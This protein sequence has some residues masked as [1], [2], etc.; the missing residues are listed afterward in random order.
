MPLLGL[1]VPVAYSVELAVT[2]VGPVEVAAVVQTLPVL[3]SD[4][5]TAVIVAGLAEAVVG[6]VA[7]V[8]DSRYFA[9]VERHAGLAE[10]PEPPVVVVA[11]NL[12]LAPYNFP[13]NLILG[14]KTCLLISFRFKL[15][16]YVSLEEFR[17]S[18]SSYLDEDK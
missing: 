1:V 15:K 7:I 2:A 18:T 10:Q 12:I 13:L 14:I 3:L 9:P 11:V 5:D 6:L 4:F 8:E 17:F 16:D